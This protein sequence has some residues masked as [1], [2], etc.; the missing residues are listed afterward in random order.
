MFFSSSLDVNDNIPRCSNTSYRVTIPENSSIDKPLIKINGT[1]NDNGLN[2]T[3]VYSFRTNST[4]PFVLNDTTGEI[5][6]KSPFDYESDWRSFSLIVDLK[7]RGEPISH[8]M[9]NA[10]LVEI[11]VEDINDNRPEL[12]DDRQREIFLDR[13]LSH[14]Q[15]IPLN[16]TDRDAGENGRLKFTLQA[17]ESN[18]PLNSTDGFFRMHSNG[19][20]QII[21]PI[22]AISLF[23]LQI[24]VEDHGSPSQTNSISISIAVG[25]RTNPAYS[26]FEKIQQLFE[27]QQSHTNQFAFL[28]G[29]TLLILTFICLISMLISCLLI[30]QHH[31]RRQAALIARKQ[32]LCVSTQQL[33]TSDSTTSSL[34]HQQTLFPA[35]SWNTRASIDR[36]SSG[37]LIECFSAADAHL[38][39][40]FDV[41]QSHSPASHTYK[42]LHVPVQYEKDRSDQLSCDH[43][44]HGSTQTRSPSSTSTEALSSQTSVRRDS[45]VNQL[46]YFVIKC[47]TLS[48]GDTMIEMNVDGSDE[49]AH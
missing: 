34:E 11:F 35:P 8:E 42:I 38:L 27:E 16:I 31:R 18:L 37:W 9:F 21:R 32:L 12:T 2:G 25:D 23:K 17:V 5:F 13:R 26:S 14:Q 40:S 43:G 47:K 24:F 39:F 19:S 30:R 15:I 20:L 29:L 10:C 22:E 41:G 44:Y 48:A 6:S 36:Y 49:D 3:I 46:P 28:F 33:T 1:D 45:L 4:W 7:D